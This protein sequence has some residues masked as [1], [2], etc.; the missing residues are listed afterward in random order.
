MLGERA[1]REAILPSRDSLQFATSDHASQYLPVDSS[2]RQFAG[3]DALLAPRQ[4]QSPRMGRSGCH[5]AN[6]RH[7]CASVNLSPQPERAI[8][9]PW[10]TPI[11]LRATN[12]ARLHRQLDHLG[13]GGCTSAEGMGPPNASNPTCASS[14]LREP[15]TVRTP[16][17]PVK[18]LHDAPGGSQCRRCG[19][20]RGESNQLDRVGVR[21]IHRHDACPARE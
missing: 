21:R 14:T 20:A 7:S 1:L 6:G 19:V 5:V 2:C 9:I 11:A 12:V 17:L 4:F 8:R 3:A 15:A 10:G 16:R 13:G 18:G